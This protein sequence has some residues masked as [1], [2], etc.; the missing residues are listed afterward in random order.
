MKL[1]GIFHI[2]VCTIIRKLVF[3]CAAKCE[4]ESLNSSLLQVQVL[5]GF[6][7]GYFAFIADIK[8]EKFYHV[9][10]PGNDKDYL[11]FL[12]WPD[13]SHN[14]AGSEYRMTVSVLHRTAN[15]FGGEYLPEAQKTM[16]RFFHVCV[17][18]KSM[19][20]EEDL[21]PTAKDVKSQCSKGGF[22]LTKFMSNIK[23]LLESLT[24]KHK[25]KNVKELY[26]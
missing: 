18:L 7:Q 13:G 8:S 26:L 25:G 6:R 3:I 10:V 17:C 4:N 9:C 22:D 20:M 19:D 5:L 12:W 1:F 23:N 2:I 24:L 16:F 14:Q 11:R 15:Y 21:V